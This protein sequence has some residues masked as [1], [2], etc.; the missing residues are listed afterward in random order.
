M[1]VKLAGQ[2][3]TTQDAVV[4]DPTDTFANFTG[5]SVEVPLQL[6]VGAFNA[7]FSFGAMGSLWYP[8]LQDSSGAP[9]FGPVAWLYFRGGLFLD[10]GS[11]TV[12]VSASTRTQELPGGYAFLSWPIPFEAGA[13][14]HVLIPGTRILVS[15][16][17]AGEYRD[18]SY[19]YFMGGAGLGFLY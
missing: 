15:A 8:Y 3:I 1:Q 7:L 4:V 12:G 10:L 14:V 9:I 2:V 17:F 11:A 13:E 6:T 19:Y 5:L 18:A 16:I